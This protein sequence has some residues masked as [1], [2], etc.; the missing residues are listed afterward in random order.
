MGR[1]GTLV[2]FDWKNLVEIAHDDALIVCKHLTESVLVI[3]SIR[4]FCWKDTQGILQRIHAILAS[5]WALS[6]VIIIQTYTSQTFSSLTNKIEIWFLIFIISARIKRMK[7]N[8]VDVKQW[9][10]FF[11]EPRNGNNVT[12]HYCQDIAI[13]TKWQWHPH[14]EYIQHTVDLS[15]HTHGVF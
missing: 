9:S 6:L 10:R 4:S 1:S 8:Y 7:R 12:G 11:S 2:N 5:K 13:H 15:S 3:G 14:K